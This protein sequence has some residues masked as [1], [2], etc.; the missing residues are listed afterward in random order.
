MGMVRVGDVGEEDGGMAA[1]AASTP[2]ESGTTRQ[3]RGGDMTGQTQT[4][5][6]IRQLSDIFGPQFKEIKDQL[7]NLVTRREHEKDL[8]E[9]NADFSNQQ[10][11][12]DRLQSWADAR[13]RKS[14]DADWVTRIETDVRAIETQLAGRPSETRATLNTIFSGGGCLYMVI[15][16]IVVIVFDLITIAVSVG[17][18]LALR[19]G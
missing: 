5:D 12:L 10:R 3:A 4:Q 13:P 18:A 16:L 8:S 19:G 15:A 14:A 11:Q 7:N 17:L 2:N 1:R 6:I 9:I